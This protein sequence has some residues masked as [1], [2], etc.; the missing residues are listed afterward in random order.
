VRRMALEV[1]E[2]SVRLE[3]VHERHGWLPGISR[4]WPA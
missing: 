2:Q 3:L 4:A 1:P